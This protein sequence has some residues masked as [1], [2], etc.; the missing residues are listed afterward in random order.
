MTEMREP[1]PVK[2]TSSRCCACR[3]PVFVPLAYRIED[4]GRFSAGRTIP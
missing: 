2:A 4:A 3:G 1:L